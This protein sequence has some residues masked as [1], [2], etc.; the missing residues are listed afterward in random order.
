MQ[1][2]DLI[3]ESPICAF[4]IKPRGDRSP[5]A[6]QSTVR[7]LLAYRAVNSCRLGER[8]RSRKS[9][10]CEESGLPVND[11]YTDP[12]WAYPP[13]GRKVELGGLQSVVPRLKWESGL[14]AG[15]EGGLTVI[16]AA[17]LLPKKRQLRGNR[18]SH[19]EPRL[20]NSLRHR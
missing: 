16:D 11:D 19:G 12:R 10:L 13:G 20:G 4:A 17:A 5:A 14:G 3:V 2:W 6:G 7:N 1:S 9:H 15:A 8:F 18:R